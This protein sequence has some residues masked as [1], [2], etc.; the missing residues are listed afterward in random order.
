MKRQEKRGFT[1]LEVLTATAILV[2]ACVLVLKISTQ[3]LD[4]WGSASESLS[5]ETEG[6]LALDV[7]EED[8]E[9]AFPHFWVYSASKN[10]DIQNGIRLCLY[11]EGRNDELNTLTYQAGYDKTKKRYG[12]YRCV[13]TDER[14]K[15]TNLLYLSEISNPEQIPL[16]QIIA[17]SNLL[18][19]NITN[20]SIRFQYKDEVGNKQW[21]SE[22][23]FIGLPICAEIL[24]TTN[25]GN[26]LTRRVTFMVNGR[27]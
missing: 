27:L 5:A 6:N 4:T 24:L 23:P 10:N 21:T 3:I 25:D 17:S 9:T 11:R 12:L 16:K 26:Q 14:K 2:M 1:L 22:A 20:F 13:V 18:A 15:L 7:M 8:L 19:K